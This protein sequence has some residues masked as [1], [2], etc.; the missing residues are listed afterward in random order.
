MADA[1]LDAIKNVLAE[2]EHI[3]IRVFGTFS[4]RERK[5]RLARNPR[6]GEQVP[7]ESRINATFKPSKELRA[8]V[9]KGRA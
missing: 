8:L 9:E 4:T 6:T 3:E 1:F 2:G 5:P 7:V